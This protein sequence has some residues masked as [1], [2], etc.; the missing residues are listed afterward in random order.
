MKKFISLLLAILM[1]TS[2][3]SLNV[4]AATV[5][6][7]TEMSVVKTQQFCNELFEYILKCG[8]GEYYFDVDTTADG[9]I[10]GSPDTYT[11]INTFTPENILSSDKLSVVQVNSHD[12]WFKIIGPEEKYTT[13][14][15]D[16]YTFYSDT[17][18]HESNPCGYAYYSEFSGI[19]SIAKS[20]LEPEQY[21]DYFPHI[22]NKPEDIKI[23][24]S[25][26]KEKYNYTLRLTNL[27]AIN[28]NFN[29]YYNLSN[30]V[31]FM[32]YDKYIGCCQFHVYSQQIKYDL[33][34]F[35]AS[36]DNAYTVEDAYDAGVLTDTYA[37]YD[38]IS[39]KGNNYFTFGIEKMDDIK[40]RFV[41]YIRANGA[42]INNGSSWLDYNILGSFDDYT[43]C[44]GGKYLNGKDTI[45]VLGDYILQTG[46]T[47]SPYSPGIYLIDD[48][49]VYTIE[50]LYNQGILK[51]SD[52]ERFSNFLKMDC[53][54]TYGVTFERADALI[55]FFYEKGISVSWVEDLGK[56][57]NYQLCYAGT[58]TTS[59]KVYELTIGNYTFSSNKQ[60]TPYSIGLYIKGED[61]IYT[62]GEAYDKG[63]IDD[64]YMDIIYRTLYNGKIIDREY[65]W[66]ITS[67]KLSTKENLANYLIFYGALPQ[68]NSYTKYK[69]V[70]YGEVGDYELC[71]MPS[72]TW[73]NKPSSIK[74]NNYRIKTN[75]TYNPS[76]TGLYLVKGTEIHI[77][78]MTFYSSDKFSDNDIETIVSLIR[79]KE[80]T[81]TED[82]PKVEVIND[83]KP[84]QPYIEMG[85]NK[86][87]AGKT[88][89]VT[90]K[91]ANGEK[92]TFS[93]KNRKIATINKK[94]V[95]T[96]LKKGTATIVATVG[97][98]KLTAKIK[99]TTNP[100]I[101]KSGKPIDTI[102]IKKGSCIKVKITGKA[103]KIKNTYTFKNNIKVLSNKNASVIKIKAV[104]EG[105][106]TL[107]IKVNGSK[108]LKLT[109][110]VH[111]F[112][113]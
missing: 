71:F 36:N 82:I 35:I 52:L 6:N 94:G 25:L 14:D 7:S 2:C 16:D 5:N 54:K 87:K 28:E 17:F 34:L 30:L 112:D 27:G 56:V 76:F 81:S 40:T 79:A 108:I 11:Y 63:I 37:L 100:Q 73:E 29:L 111:N 22:N 78:G 89:V 46:S 83:N 26:L 95:V 59:D 39:S 13:E 101:K 43:V 1:L 67:S 32:D 105:I 44:Y 42:D 107:K 49:S 23:A 55:R 84:A 113:I 65:N 41:E 68:E 24:E 9:Y 93:T 74:R 21:A 72:N 3:F 69:F 31:T 97:N 15:I 19:S 106:S 91:N 8:L 77:F 53:E 99:V 110:C 109:V 96:G 33:G 12:V 4:F 20:S 47:Y 64:S 62:L 86:I 18:F 70:N 50:D 98:K 92:T 57:G 60:Q 51:D 80:N 45:T 75:K 48:K 61:V 66:Y 85:S 90:I 102:L 104:K 88:T 58:N 103:P 38:I 10:E